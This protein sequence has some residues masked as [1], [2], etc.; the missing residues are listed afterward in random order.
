[1]NYEDDNR[2]LPAKGN[3]TTRKRKRMTMMMTT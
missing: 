3:T 2:K 1:M